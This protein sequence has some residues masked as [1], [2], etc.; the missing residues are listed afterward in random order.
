MNGYFKTVLFIVL[1]IPLASQAQDA[2]TLGYYLETATV[3]SP[4]LHDYQN[5]RDAVRIDSLKFRADYGVKVNGQGDALYAPVF[6]GWGYD[7]AISNGQSVDLLIRASRDFLSRKNKDTRLAGYS[8][9][10]DQLQNQSSIT[11]LTLERAITEQYIITYGSQRQYEVVEEVLRLL[12]EEDI[13][14]KKLTQ[15]AVFKQ[16]DYLSFKV[17]LQ[18]NLL[19]LQQ[20]KTDWRNDYAVLNYLSGVV[21][22][23]LQKLAPPDIP[24]T[25]PQGFE[26]SIYAESYRTDSLKLDNEARVIHYDYRPKISAFADGGYS[27]SLTTTPYK[28]FGTSAGVA[29]TLPIYDGHKRN[30]SLRQNQLSME[31]RATYNA[32]AK[33]QY[34][35]QL[36]QLTAQIQQY[37]Q[38]TVTATEQ[39]KYAQ[40]LIEANMKQ[41]PTGDVRVADFILS[42][43]NYINLK[44][45]LVQYE[46]TLYNLYNHLHHLILQ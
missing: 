23:S 18:Q 34:Q 38:L 32:F 17:T 45:G 29:V 33:K 26:E 8:L 6:R 30:L 28:N 46:T 7:A 27:S 20:H 43:S 40:T 5:Q 11:R 22:T 2:K 31:T 10:I 9:S 4:V 25:V 13:I 15:N 44:S 36:Q 14:L 16:T 3:N 1:L 42:I 35:Q 39:M 21:D 19:S 37:R 41:L 24:D 12:N